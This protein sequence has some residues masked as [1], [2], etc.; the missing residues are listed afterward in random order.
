MLA[1]LAAVMLAAA[2]QNDTVFT[3]DGGRVVGMVVEEGPEGVA[4]RLP[5]G[6][7]R[8]YARRDVRR[9]EYA[10]G[11]VSRITE[12][13]PPPAAQAPPTPP[14]VYTPPPPQAYPPPPA[15]VPP[16][17][18]RYPPPPYA[19]RPPPP[20]PPPDPRA[21]PLAPF[22]L[23]F[24]LGGSFRGGEAQDDV[25][26]DRV[27][28][29]QLDLD[30]EGGVRVTPHLAIGLY[31]DVGV[32]DPSRE[33]RDQCNAPLD[34]GPPFDCHATTGRF[35]ILLRHTFD[36]G[37]RVTPWFSVGTGYE[38]GSISTDDS[39]AG[40]DDLLTYS[41][42]E[43]ARLQTGLDFRS[44]GVIGIGFYAGVGLG[45]Y[46][47]VEDVDGTDSFGDRKSLHTTVE[48]GIR[49]TLFP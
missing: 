49:F 17:P 5:D 35:G 8:R 2:P 29:N 41:G 9:I 46:S 40:D 28:G 43:I 19:Y 12:P 6:S 48:G 18:P 7:F 37:G 45:R 34:G 22:Y 4:L 44:Q 32:G 21:G 13:A 47:K 42:W 25:D 31:A 16:P 33:I 38:Y 27:F 11:S 36:P 10:D 20:P 39:G 3:T 1:I 15:Y 14:P 26:I 24:G 23:S 30:F